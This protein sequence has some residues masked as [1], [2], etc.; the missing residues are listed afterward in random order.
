MMA[1]TPLALAKSLLDAEQCS[2]RKISY[3]ILT[4]TLQIDPAFIPIFYVRNKSTERLSNWLPVTQL[5]CQRPTPPS[6]RP[7]VL[8]VRV[9]VFSI[10]LAHF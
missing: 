6:S 3:R 8:T 2:R 7:H 9:D 5:V 10:R 4:V 1:V